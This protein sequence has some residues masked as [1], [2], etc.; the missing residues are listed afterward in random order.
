MARRSA[1]LLIVH[2]SELATMAGPPR[3][4][5]GDEMANVGAVEEGALAIRDG[6]VLAAG[7]TSEILQGFS[8]RRGRPIDASGKTVVP[9]FI[10]PHTHPVFAGT[11]EGELLMKL[12]GRSY[13]EILKAGGGIMSTVR[14]TRSATEGELLSATLRRLD[15]M[16]LHGTTTVEG[17][18]GYGLDR[19]T[20]LRLLRVLRAAGR[21][22]PVDVVPTFLG[23]HA[24]PPEFEGKAEEYLDFIIDR[25]LPDV[26]RGRLAEYCDV[27][28]EEGVFTADQSRRLL[29]SAR[30]RGLRPRIHADELSGSGGAELA[31]ELGAVSADHLVR[32]SRE[33]LRRMA[34]AGVIGV[35]LPGA[36]LS[37]MLRDH[38]DA[39]SMISMGLPL[40][41]ATDLN[42]NCM[43]NSMPLMVGL[44]CYSMHLRPSEALTAS[45]I[46]AAW[47]LERGEELGSLEPGKRADA[48]VLDAPNHI[49]IAYRF[50]ANLVDTVLKDGRVVVRGGRLVGRG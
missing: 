13:L 48:V 39:R 31:A 42:P 24:V 44:A 10:D 35:L 34:E 36:V 47:A 3:P 16:L 7:P 41:L 14:A 1:D 32:A 6:L 15:G 30:R 4:R 43:M 19:F 26:A 28:C 46:N 33:G 8:Q 21:R 2:A 45:T 40:A 11:R 37:L 50:G 22:H 38:P 23:A 27:F 20:E 5:R 18:S 9:G 25:V 29:I 12:E 49:H 17:K